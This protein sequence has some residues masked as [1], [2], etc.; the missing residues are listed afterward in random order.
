MN[1]LIWIYSEISNDIKIIEEIFILIKV[2]LDYTLEPKAV[3]WSFVIHRFT[4]SVSSY[5]LDATDNLRQDIN[6]NDYD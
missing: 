5:R 1:G 6:S 3:T 4:L 2:A